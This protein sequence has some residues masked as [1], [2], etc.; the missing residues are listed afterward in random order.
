M[1]VAVRPSIPRHWSPNRPNRVAG[2]VACALICLVTIDATANAGRLWP[3]NRLTQTAVGSAPSANSDE[4]EKL[5]RQLNDLTNTVSKAIQ[6][7]RY[8]VAIVPAEQACQVAERL[9]QLSPQLQDKHD[10]VS[11]QYTLGR[12]FNLLGRQEEARPQLE[13]AVGNLETFPQDEEPGK[14]AEL[15]DCWNELGQ[16]SFNMGEYPRSFEEIWKASEIYRKNAA[17]R[18]KKPT[19]DWAISLNNLGATKL[20]LGELESASG[21]FDQA[22]EILKPV[23]V[24]VT[25]PDKPGVT[26]SPNDDPTSGLDPDQVRAVRTAAAS[27]LDNRGVLALKRGDIDEAVRNCAQAKA[28]LERVYSRDRFPLGH[29][30]L[31][32][33]L[34]NLGEAQRLTGNFEEAWNNLAGSLEMAQGL[35]ETNALVLLE[36]EALSFAAN[37]IPS[38]CGS[39]LALVEGPATKNADEVY[40]RIWRSKAAV[41][42][43]IQ[44]RQRLLVGDRDPSM[45]ALTLNLHEGQDRLSHLLRLPL[46]KL[47]LPLAKEV[48]KLSNENEARERILAGNA[49]QRNRAREPFHNSHHEL[50]ASLP[51]K[52]VF[53]DLLR[54]SSI[55]HNERPVNAKGKPAAKYAAFVL[56]RGR[57]VERVELGDAA[58]VEEYLDDWR[59]GIRAHRDRDGPAEGKLRSRL[60]EPV[61]GRFPRG[62]TT[63]IVSPDAALARLPWAALPGSNAGSRLIEDYTIVM[64]PHGPELLEWLTKTPSRD[65]DILTVENLGSVESVAGGPADTRGVNASDPTNTSKAEPSS[66]PTVG[67]KELFTDIGKRLMGKALQPLRGHDATTVKLREELPKARWAYFAAHGY[68]ADTE[69]PASKSKTHEDEQR[70]TASERTWQRVLARNP[71]LRSGIVLDDG[72]MTAGAIAGLPLANLDVAFLGACNTGRGAIADGEGVLGLQRAFHMGGTRNVVATLWEVDPS[73]IRALVSEFH[74]NLGDDRLSKPEALRRAQLKIR[75]R[76]GDAA[77]PFYWAAWIVSGDPRPVRVV[78]DELPRPTSNQAAVWSYPWW[79]WALLAI[80]GCLALMEAIRRWRARS[81]VGRAPGI[82]RRN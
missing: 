14:S 76:G 56:A 1:S 13:K 57:P 77:D 12:L 7:A 82:P 30:D 42:R 20:R 8:D 29:P 28:V 45:D 40:A 2:R 11:W 33:A 72:E 18:A 63:V 36:G 37:E 58:S 41:T 38:R 19:Y 78:R 80:V 32:K 49:L 17:G 6:S 35:V 52:T 70:M 10:M 67:P 21:F 50:T 66:E 24:Y 43:V 46:S 34:Y 3:V 47:T 55:P 39:L 15:A 62:T 74:R 71:M 4:I 59:T 79:A 5:R 44:F 48:G 26:S 64:A 54:Y 75:E 69:Q 23:C 60:W 65:G 27:C 25:R 53:V 9:Y 31:S 16:V 22:W 61:E 73:S 81:N 51:E 68:F